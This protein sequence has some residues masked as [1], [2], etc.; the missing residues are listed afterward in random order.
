MRGNMTEGSAH[1]RR[2]P[3]S[4]RGLVTR[5]LGSVLVILGVVYTVIALASRFSVAMPKS[6]YLPVARDY[7]RAAWALDSVTLVGQHA[8]PQAVQWGLN[9]WR[10]LPQTP[11]ARL[12]GL[13]ITSAS[14]RDGFTELLLHG[15]AVGDCAE[16]PLAMTVSGLP[17]SARVEAVS[18][19]CD[20]QWRR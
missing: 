7:L 20:T 1:G 19:E 12:R 9:A 4:A 10:H 2:R 17:E 13:R 8:S 5:A 6:E 14:T 3:W 15:W 16:R 11:I 18:T